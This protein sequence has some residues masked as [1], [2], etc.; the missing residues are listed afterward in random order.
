MCYYY[1]R[2]TKCV[3]VLYLLEQQVAMFLRPQVEEEDEDRADA[4]YAWEGNVETTWLKVRET[5]E[6]KLE[7]DAM[8]QVQYLAIYPRFPLSH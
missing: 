6:G 4:V 1:S 8:D 7:C 5:E 2:A 3:G